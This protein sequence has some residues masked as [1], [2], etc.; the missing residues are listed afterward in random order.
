M[1]YDLLVFEKWNGGDWDVIKV[2]HPFIKSILYDNFDPNVWQARKLTSQ[3]YLESGSWFFDKS[4]VSDRTKDFYDAQIREYV[5][6]IDPTLVEYKNGKP[7][8]FKN[9]FTNP[10]LF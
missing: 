2:H 3:F 4:F 5:Q 8:N 7:R 10:V 1:A 9:F 6:G